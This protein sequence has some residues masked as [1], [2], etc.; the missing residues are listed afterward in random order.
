MSLLFPDFFDKGRV[1]AFGQTPF[2]VSALTGRVTVVLPGDYVRY[3]VVPW[4]DALA[5]DAEEERYVRHHF[6]RVYGERAKGWT[7]RASPAAAGEA[8]LC[9]A[10]DAPVVESIRAAFQ[11]KKA[12]LVSIQPA[13]MTAFNRARSSIPREGAWLVLAEAGRACVALYA[14]GWRSVLNAR[15][16]WQDLLARERHRA[17]GRIPEKV[18]NL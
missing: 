7:L 6:I 10:V 16:A 15:G 18:I 14:G 13:L 17:E 8:R 11:G 12:K 9:S 3:A 4:S 2:D 1:V 5:G